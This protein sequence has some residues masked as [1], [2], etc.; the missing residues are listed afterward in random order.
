VQRA[1]VVA[2]LGRPN[3]GKST[4]LNSVL[5]AK[6]AIVTPK[7]QTTRSR[8]LGI[9]T[10]KHAQI[11]FLDTPG[12]HR[13]RRVMNALLSAQ[14][15]EAARDCDVALLLVDLTESWGEDHAELAASLAERGAP[16]FAV[17]T[18]LDLCDA[19]AAPWPPPGVE[20]AFRISARIGT[21]IPRL[22]DAI[23]EH[24]PESP[25][26]FPASDLSDRPVRF[27]AAELIREA[28]FEELAQ[29][30]PYS[31]AVEVLEFDEADAGLVRIRAQLLVERRS[32]KQIAVGRGGSMIKCIGTRARLE[33][34]RLVGSRV[35]LDLRVKVEPRWAKRPSRIKALGYI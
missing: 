22:L 21:G 11:L 35:Y 31:L 13:G 28:A 32:Q 4:L 26:L 23:V 30:L 6:L 29:E 16:A 24:L 17:G 9:H 27:L 19:A 7:P 10:L 20:R 25:P 12:L 8:I 15:K 33:I 34:E 18:K 5:G 14:V 1:G 2:I 3:A